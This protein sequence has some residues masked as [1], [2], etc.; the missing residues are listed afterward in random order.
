MSILFFY[1]HVIYTIECKAGFISDEWYTKKVIQLNKLD[2]MDIDSKE[3]DEQ[4]P[5]AS[6]LVSSSQS[7]S[8][9]VDQI[10]KLL[11]SIAD[12]GLSA[13]FDDQ[14]SISHNNNHNSISDDQHELLNEV[15]P[16]EYNDNHN[17][18][19]AVGVTDS[20]YTPMQCDN[21]DSDNPNQAVQHDAQNAVSSEVND[22][23]A[24]VQCGN[25]DSDNHNQ[26]VQNDTQ[27]NNDYHASS[28][29]DSLGLSYMEDSIYHCIVNG[30][31]AETRLKWYTTSPFAKKTPCIC[32]RSL[33]EDQTVLVS[34]CEQCGSVVCLHCDA[35]KTLID[36]CDVIEDAQ[37]KDDDCNKHHF[38]P[39]PIKKEHSFVMSNKCKRCKK[40]LLFQ[41]SKTGATTITVY[42]CIKCLSVHCASCYAEKNE[43]GDSNMPIDDND[44]NDQDNDFEMDGTSSAEEDNGNLQIITNKNRNISSNCG[45]SYPSSWKSFKV[46]NKA[47]KY[48][49]DQ[50][51]KTKVR[52]L[53][54]QIPHANLLF[55]TK[56]PKIIENRSPV[57]A[58]DV[59]TV[60]YATAFNPKNF[61]NLIND[62]N[63]YL[64]LI[65]LHYPEVAEMF[66]NKAIDQKQLLKG[67]KEFFADPTQFQ[68]S[69]FIG[70]LKFTESYAGDKN[71]KNNAA[72]KS[73][74]RQLGYENIESAGWAK[75]K[76]HY[77]VQK[78]ITF[79][80]P[81]VTSVK[82]GSTKHERIEYYFRRLYE[83]MD[84][85]NEAVKQI[86]TIYEK[87]LK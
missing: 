47:I 26:A 78:L 15:F 54:V 20:S 53:S 66:T 45:T 11:S 25:N 62:N 31:R 13:S 49:V 84:D 80:S 46:Q 29:R 12:H 55:K 39:W 52:G 77:H 81:I 76:H 6:F 33:G 82:I 87:I 44:N 40:D 32:C 35:G 22:L 36:N 79:E 3:S 16:N 14:H 27:N 48:M 57:M 37:A 86:E 5:T 67:L 43:D 71:D 34:P 74:I 23:C 28:S 42:A 17:Q 21:N 51:N 75:D 68:A 41:S 85:K 70:C 4:I 63:G 83:K 18:N 64:G 2:A 7:E 50:L 59:K 30:C 56:L 69:C 38:I 8:Q 61:Q 60:I 19:D 58:L 24:P 1:N 10:E 9:Q 65:S 72:I 73:M